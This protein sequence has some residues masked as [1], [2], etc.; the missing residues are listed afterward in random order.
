MKLR[1]WA[2]LLLAPLWACASQPQSNAP[3]ASAPSAP[4]PSAGTSAAADPAAQPSGEPSVLSLL[5]TPFYIA[6]KVPFCGV[7]AL[8][9]PGALASAIIPFKDKNPGSG[10]DLMVAEV[11]DACG[12]PYVAYAH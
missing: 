1:P 10:G 3:S 9:A 5:A 8:A 4:P 7:S 6:L 12:P 11:K 2:I